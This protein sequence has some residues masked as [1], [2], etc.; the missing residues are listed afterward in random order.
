MIRKIAERLARTQYVRDALEHPPDLREIRRNPSPRVWTGLFLVGLSYVLGW[1]A[2][3]ALGVL[4]VWF[5]EPL[6]LAV[7]GPLTYGLSHVLFLVGAWL[8]GARYVRL[9]MKHATGRAFEKILRRGAPP[10]AR[11]NGADRGSDKSAG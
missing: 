9:L 6:I 5:R 3:G 8:A 1:P 2:V 4:A 10:G 7:G 11:G